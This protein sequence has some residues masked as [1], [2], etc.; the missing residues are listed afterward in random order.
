MQHAAPVIGRHLQQK[1]R[2]IVFGAGVPPPQG[3]ARCIAGTH[4]PQCSFLFFYLDLLMQ[5]QR[6]CG[7]SQLTYV[8][9]EHH[10]GAYWITRAKHGRCRQGGFKRKKCV[11]LIGSFPD[12]QEA[13]LQQL[14]PACHARRKHDLRSRC[15]ASEHAG[16]K[17]SS[18]LCS[19][20]HLSLFL[21][22]CT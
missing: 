21:Y 12:L 13:V 10:C 17:S 7:A 18:C 4:L 19:M 2:L 20:S 14:P 16:C 22:R 1:G 15:A 6:I 9:C 11:A 3:N 8:S 5:V